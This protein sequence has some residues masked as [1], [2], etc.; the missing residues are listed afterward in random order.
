MKVII[1]KF[2]K[3]TEI[4]I[5]FHNPKNLVMAMSVEA[6]ELVEIFQW[7]D[8]ETS[9][10]SYRKRKKEHVKQEIAD[11]VVYLTRICMT[12]NIDLEKAILEKNE[13]E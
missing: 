3:K 9:A 4:G 5:K 12:Y 11:I 7:L 10:K 6:S 2:F 8:F 13:N 1:S